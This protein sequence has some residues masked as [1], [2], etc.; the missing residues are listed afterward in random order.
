MNATTLRGRLLRAL[1]DDLRRAPW[2][3]SPCHVAGHCYVASEAMWHALGGKDSGFTPA[4][5]RHEGATHWFLRNART[6]DVLDLTADQFS[7]PVP[8]SRGRGCGFLTRSPSR[9]ARIVL[10]RMGVSS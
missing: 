7:S 8:Y 6:G 9:R 2:R 10:Y 3:G 5:I 4:V 1:T